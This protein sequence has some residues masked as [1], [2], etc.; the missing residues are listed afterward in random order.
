MNPVNTNVDLGTNG[1]SNINTGSSINTSVN[2]GAVSSNVNTSTYQTSAQISQQPVEELDLSSETASDNRNIFQK[3]GD[4][5]ADT[6]N[7]VYN[8]GAEIVNDIKTWASSNLKGAGSSLEET[9]ANLASDVGT[10]VSKLGSIFLDGV[11]ALKSTEAVIATSV[12]S[13]VAK[14][15]EH[16]VDAAL[17][18][19]GKLIEGRAYV[20]GTIVGLFNKDAGDAIKNAG[21]QAN[22]QLKEWI[23]FDAVGEANKWF[24]ESTDLG[25]WIND[26]SLMKYDSE[27]AMKIR[28]VS[29]KAAEFAAATALTVATGGLATFAVGALYGIGK[30]AES[31]YQKNGTDTTLLQEAGI[32]GAGGLTGLSWLANGKLGSGFIEIGKAATEVGVGEVVSKISKDILTKDFWLK[33]FKDGLT[34]VNGL[35]NYAASAMMTGEE[36]IPY[37][38]GEKPWDAEAVEHIALCYLKNLGYNVAEDALREYIGGFK[39]E[40][41]IEAI[42]GTRSKVVDEVVDADLQDLTPEDNAAESNIKTDDRINTDMS[43]SRKD[44]DYN[45]FT[46][47]VDNA[48]Y[49][50]KIDG[51]TFKSDTQQGLKD[52]VS[53]YNSIIT[54]NKID[55]GYFTNLLKSKDVVI[56]DIGG[57]GSFQVTKY[58]HFDPTAIKNQ[59][60]TTFFHECGHFLDTDSAYRERSAFE[61][62]IAFLQDPRSYDVNKGL[63]IFE[64]DVNRLRAQVARMVDARRGD[65][66][67]DAVSEMPRLYQDWDKLLPDMQNKLINDLYNSKVSDLRDDLFRNSGLTSISDIFDAITNGRVKD[68]IG[69]Y[70]H[71]AEYYNRDATSRYMETLA[72]ISALYNSGQMKMLDRYFPPAVREALTE[73]Y[74]RLINV[75][76]L[77]KVMA[78]SAFFQDSKYSSGSF[79][80][81]LL[82]YLVNHDPKVLTRDHG[83]RDLVTSMPDESIAKFLTLDNVFMQKLAEFNDG[84]DSAYGSGYFIRCIESYL[85]GTNGINVFTRQGNLRQFMSLLNKS[86]IQDFLNAMRRLGY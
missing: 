45:L 76:Q 1:N 75:D 81:G 27:A 7:S 34:G 35:G 16:L 49:T 36:I 57:G 19:G 17:W 79:I 64:A 14:L 51:I 40:K 56:T 52:L 6:A 54:N 33:A 39:A 48:Q 50:A 8:T 67:R 43:T 74:E 58:I 24:Y 70:G 44:W 18:C 63:S 80:N 10:I 62:L 60:I 77:R 47:Q 2:T 25:R 65:L 28:E 55:G 31:T 86:Q 72:N 12:V 46:R 3:A 68:I 4:W 78:D 11:K 29:E 13:G 32:V 30:Q 23:A 84:V 9:A 15:G 73:T 59:S 41:A 38:N 20:D 22:Q 5:I 85:N 83:I 69:F 71:G 37:L 82:D 66:W 42:T 21:H 53:Y 61:S 26:N